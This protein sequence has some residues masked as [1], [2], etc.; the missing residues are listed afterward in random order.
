MGFDV[1]EITAIIPN[2][3]YSYYNITIQF[4]VKLDEYNYPGYIWSDSKVKVNAGD[5]LG[6]RFLEITKGVAGV[7]TIHQPTNSTKAEVL[8]RF[9]E[10]RPRERFEELKRKDLEDAERPAPRRRPMTNSWRRCLGS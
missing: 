4:R 8:Q 6:G 1:G 10:K 9:M 5:L 7:P 3:P 2:D